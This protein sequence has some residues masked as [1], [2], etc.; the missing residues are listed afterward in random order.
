MK[1]IAFDAL[2]KLFAAIAE[3]Y[4]LYLPAADGDDPRRGAKFTPWTEEVT[5]AADAVNTVR[6]AKDFFFPQVERLVNFKV[7]G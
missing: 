7:S 3:Q 1:Q 2:P 5:Y 6:S 4:A